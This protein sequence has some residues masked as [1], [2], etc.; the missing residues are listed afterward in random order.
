M[1]AV[2]EADERLRAD[3]VREQGP[4]QRTSEAGGRLARAEGKARARLLGECGRREQDR[5][6]RRAGRDGGLLAVGEDV[7]C[8]G[9]RRVV[10]AGAARHRVDLPVGDVDRVVPVPGIDVQGRRRGAGREP[11]VAV[12]ERD[13][14]RAVDRAVDGLEARRNAAAVVSERVAGIA[15][16]HHLRHRAGADRDLVAD[17]RRGR[18]RQLRLAGRDRGGGARGAREDSERARQGEGGEEEAHGGAGRSDGGSRTGVR[19]A[20]P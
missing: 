16:A 20:R 10:R 11:V 12:A 18:D 17:A 8:V 14:D 2:G 1:G 15:D 7:L 4:V 13:G 6:V 3:A 19:R 9:A 5:R